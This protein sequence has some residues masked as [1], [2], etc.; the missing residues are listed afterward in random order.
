MPATEYLKAPHITTVGP[1]NILRGYAK[2]CCG[3]T[4]NSNES[5]LKKVR[6]GITSL[7][8]VLRITLG[9]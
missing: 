7:E 1:T 9:M 6:D 4:N 3:M 2:S 8:E 5:G